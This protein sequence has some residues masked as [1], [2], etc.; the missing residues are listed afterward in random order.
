[1]RAFSSFRE[2]LGHYLLGNEAAVAFNLLFT[3]VLHLWDDLIDRDHP[4]KVTDEDIHRGF[5]GALV[6]LPANP[7]YR[8]YFDQLHPLIDVAILN[9]MAA[10]TLEG[11]DALTDKEIAFIVRSDY[12][13]VF[14]KSLQLVGGFEHAR[15]VLPE[16]R[17]LWH[18][19]GY[20]QYLV[21]LR[22]EQLARGVTPCF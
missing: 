7:F 19:E 12:I 3:E 10:N 4:E 14:V 20:D 15:K 8:A 18:D 9:W 11:T 6:L 2:F 21:N 1:M 17:R 16:V 13:N 5:R 22:A